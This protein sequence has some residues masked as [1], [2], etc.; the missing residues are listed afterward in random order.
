M[1]FLNLIDSLHMQKRKLL[2][3]LYFLHLVFKLK[4][5]DQPLVIKSPEGGE[6]A[7]LK[8]FDSRLSGLIVHQGQLS[9]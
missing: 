2:Q 3:K 9:E 1:N 8:A 6:I 7:S 4:L 5:L